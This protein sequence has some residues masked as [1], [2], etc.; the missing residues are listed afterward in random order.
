MLQYGFNKTLN[1]LAEFGV[2]FL[3]VQRYILF[4]FV[5]QVGFIFISASCNQS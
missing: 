4:G 3:G 2:V 5:L 1:F